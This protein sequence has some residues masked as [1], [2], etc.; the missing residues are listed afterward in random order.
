ML[1][2]HVKGLGGNPYIKANTSFM[3]IFLNQ[4]NR[5]GCAPR[6]HTPSAAEFEK[7]GAM[8]HTGCGFLSQQLGLRIPRQPPAPPDSGP[9]GQ[10]FSR[11]NPTPGEQATPPRRRGSAAGRPP[12]GPGGPAAHGPV[13]TTLNHTLPGG[14]DGPATP[15]A[16]PRGTSCFLNG[17]HGR[18]ERIGAAGLPHFPNRK[19]A[20][21]QVSPHPAPR[22]GRGPGGGGARGRAPGAGRRASGWA[23]PQRRRLRF[24]FPAR[25]GSWPRMP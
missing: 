18:R 10:P 25:R 23:E 11:G 8:G 16:V 21:P 20:R 15:A 9:G 14:T 3:H 4:R 22:D 5:H 7:Q 2:L 1:I 24:E 12:A 13:V 6:P 19:Q 17:G